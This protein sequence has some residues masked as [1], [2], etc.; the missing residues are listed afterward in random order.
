MRKEQDLFVRE[1][2]RLVAAYGLRESD[3][4]SLARR[5]REYRKALADI[6]IHCL[7][8]CVDRAIRSCEWF[9]SPAK[10]RDIWVASGDGEAGI[11]VNGT[12]LA[13]EEQERERRLCMGKAIWTRIGTLPEERQA[14]LRERARR[15]LQ[16]D[17]AEILGPRLVD[18]LIR[19]RMI[20]IFREEQNAQ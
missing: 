15:D 17:R 20:H 16:V 13:A 2:D 10:L 1:F 19:Q 11:G 6:P 3:E 14:A 7:S 8:R 4:G 12:E 9:P 18:F 5:A